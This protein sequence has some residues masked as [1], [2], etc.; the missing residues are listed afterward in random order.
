M[1]V[2]QGDQPRL[3]PSCIASLACVCMMAACPLHKQK[4][5]KR[6]SFTSLQMSHTHTDTHTY[7]FAHKHFYTQTLLHTDRNFYTQ[8]L[9]HTD[10]LTQKPFDTQKLRHTDPIYTQT[11]LHTNAYTL[12]LTPFYIQHQL[13]RNF[14]AVFAHRASFRA[15]GLLRDKSGTSKFA[16]FLQFWTIDPHFVRK[17]RKSI[18]P[19]TQND[20]RH[21]TTHVWMPRKTKQRDVWNLQKAPSYRT[22]H[23]HGHIAIART[24]ANDCERR[25]RTFATVNATSSEHTLNLRTSEWNGNPCYACGKKDLF[26]AAAV[27]WIVGCQFGFRSCPLLRH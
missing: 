13:N 6:R 7:P 20:F 18:A 25:L 17:R 21:V 2:H 22:Y 1:Q 16:I 4:T 26:P 9:L 14:T 12:T 23:R 15:K 24:V 11:L 19:A 27:K 8:T 5:N 10:T 3:P